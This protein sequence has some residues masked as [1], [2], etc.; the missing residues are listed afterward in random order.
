MVACEIEWNNLTIARWDELFANVRRSTLLQH[1]PYAQA[2][3]ATQQIGARH[4]LIHID[5][6]PAGLVQLGEVGVL[7]NAIHAIT[8][9]RGPLWFEGWSRQECTEAFFTE[10]AR[11]FPRRFGRKMRIMPEL[12]HDRSSSRLLE[13]CGL[14]RNANFHGYQTIWLDLTRDEDRLRAKLNGKWRNILSKAERSGFAVER[15]VELDTASSFLAEYDADQLRKN[16]KGTSQS[17]LLSLMKYMG[18]R[19][20]VMILNAK[21]DDE[22]IAAI[23]VLVHGRSATYQVGWTTDQGRKFG[24]HHRLL[25]EAVVTLKRE[26]V[27]DFD[28]GGVNDEGAAGVKKFKLGLGGQMVDLVGM[29]S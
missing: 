23:L 13:D 7:R 28:L 25:W 12:A 3:R 11:Q 26:V 8:L 6:Q 15:D 20:E 1:F 24:A 5:G 18:V 9:D 27:T 19:R 16:F 10:F 21:R 2:T 22:I 4:G 29:Y 17:F 14:K